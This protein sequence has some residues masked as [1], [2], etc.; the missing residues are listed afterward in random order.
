M[1]KPHRRFPPPGPVGG[2]QQT[3]RDD[4]VLRRL[5]VGNST[6]RP[7]VIFGLGDLGREALQAR[8]AELKASTLPFLNLA[9]SEMQET[10]YWRT[11]RWNVMSEQRKSNR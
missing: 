4:D 2:S 10:S 5:L 3:R 7:T 1:P 6:A 8:R 11:D 9:I